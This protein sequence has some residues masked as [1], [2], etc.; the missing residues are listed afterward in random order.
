ME[1]KPLIFIIS[2]K[3]P[4]NDPGGYP[5]YSRT[6]SHVLTTLNYEVLTLAIAKEINIKHTSYGEVRFLTTKLIRWFP[7]LGHLALA[8][9]PYYSIRFV[10]EI[11]KMVK[12]KKVNSFI[13]WGMGPW[14]FAGFFLKIILPKG[15]KM[16]LVTSYFTSTRH[17]MKGALN[18]IRI[19]DYGVAPKLRYFLV[20]EVVARVFS[21]FEKLT[22][23][24]SDQV[25]VH[26]KSSRRIIRKYFNTDKRK[27]FLFPWYN[28]IFKRSGQEPNVKK[29]KHP[30]V[31]SICRQDPRKGINFL[32]RAISEVRREIPEVQ[33]IIVGSGSFLKLNS[34]LVEKLELTKNISILGFVPDIRPILE[35]ADVAVIVPLAQ[36]SSALTVLEAMSY[37]KAIIGSDCDGIPEDIKNNISGLIVKPGDEKS[38]AN[39]LIKLIKDPLLRH[40]LGNNAYKVYANRFGFDKMK[41]E[42]ANLLVKSPKLRH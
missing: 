39:A 12:E 4:L 6:L 36:G 11:L 26:Y 14:A 7:I 42:I 15:V 41:Q 30:L 33:C 20:Y 1:T 16:R 37:G 32:I 13:V 22:L 38:L 19:K 24:A 3:S 40:R 8:A 28:E 2:G 17:E 27:I 25:V 29:Y 23:D 5:A 21:I 35:S 31:I 34:K 9:L 10:R 18:A